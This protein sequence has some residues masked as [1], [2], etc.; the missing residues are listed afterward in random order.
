M[1]K[2]CFSLITSSLLSLVVA[3]PAGAQTLSPESRQEFQRV[4]GTGGASP[5]PQVSPATSPRQALSPAT[6][7]E[8]KRVFGQGAIKGTAE[9]QRLNTPLTID[10][11][12]LTQMV[13]ANSDP[14]RFLLLWHSIAIDVTAMDHRALLAVNPATF[15][16]QLGPARTAR[17]MAI[18]HLAMYEAAI[19]FDNPRK[20]SSMLP[21]DEIKPKAGASRDAAIVE[22]AYQTLSSLY[23]G[24]INQA[25]NLGQANSNAD[26][27]L[28]EAFSLSTY[29][30]CSLTNLQDAPSSRN[31][32][33]DLGRQVAGRI[34]AWRAGDGSERT[35]PV[36]NSTFA[37]RNS[38]PYAANYAFQ[39][40]Q[41]DPVSKLSTALGGGWGGVKPFVLTSAFQ[42]RPSEEMLAGN[43]KLDGNNR[44]VYSQLKS[45][46][47]ITKLGTDARLDGSGKT[48]APGDLSDGFFVAQFWAYDGTANLCAPARLYNQVATEI[49]AHI[50]DY[51]ADMVSGSIDVNSVSDVARYY[52]L[53]NVAMGDAAIA[54]W[55]AK[56]YFQFPRPVTYIRAIQNVPHN[57]GVTRS[58]WFPLGAQNTNSDQPYNITP[59]FPSYPSGHAVF[60]GSLF[61][62]LRQFMNPAAKFQFMSDEFNQ[63]NRDVT[64]YV[65]C[66]DSVDKITVKKFCEKRTLSI[67]CAERENADSRLFMG[68][69]WVFDADDGINMGNKIAKEVFTRVMLPV[70]AKSPTMFSVD[71]AK[72]SSRASLVCDQINLPTGWDNTDPLVGF[73]ELKIERIDAN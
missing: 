21:G 38:D 4:Y 37:P 54:A 44:P 60:G 45:L 52:A 69:H 6:V 31:D 28:I 15:H 41:V 68:V 61:G 56:F 46:T 2:Y 24:L 23:P 73:G 64:N 10:S 62:V 7:Q 55:D 11:T 26:K 53:I 34:M 59:P 35:E 8:F 13:A 22:A 50:K 12:I 39:Q 58:A 20:F 70:S 63:K 40:W 1:H 49:L 30:N 18:V 48:V 42:F 71:P 65:R 57:D 16:E 47:A 25:T 14:M 43:F 9:L 72:Y 29:Y 36:W 17:A 33:I 67:D 5:A 3:L 51:P 27:C 32:G 66:L 19:R